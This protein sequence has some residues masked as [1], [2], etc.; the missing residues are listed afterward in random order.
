[1]RYSANQ[2]RTFE[3]GST[4]TWVVVFEAGGY[5]LQAI[6]II[7]KQYAPVLDVGFDEFEVKVKDIEIG[8]GIPLHFPVFGRDIPRTIDF[9]MIDDD[10]R[11]V[12]NTLKKWVQD[13]GV[14][15]GISPSADKMGIVTIYQN[16]KQGITIQRDTF[17]IF[18]ID[19]LTWKGDN[20]YQAA[21][22][23]CRVQVIGRR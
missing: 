20:D 22:F 15:Q 3:A 23:P 19:Q 14:L 18:P 4:S 17:L 21:T 6:N 1:M 2:L 12:R 7:A 10:S 11:T 8:P 9:T 16:N 5:N 13:S